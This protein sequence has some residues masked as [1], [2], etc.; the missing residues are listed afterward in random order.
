MGKLKVKLP[1][2]WLDNIKIVSILLT[3]LY[4]IIARSIQFYVYDCILLANI[5]SNFL[6]NEHIEISCQKDPFL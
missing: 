3:Q 4:K 5:K 2:L 1:M 6:L